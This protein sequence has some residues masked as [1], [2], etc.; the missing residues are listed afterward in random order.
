VIRQLRVVMSGF[1][2]RCFVFYSFVPDLNIH[3]GSRRWL[4]RSSGRRQPSSSSGQ[5]LLLFP[6]AQ[7]SR[8]S[9]A[10]WGETPVRN[11]TRPLGIGGVGFGVMLRFVTPHQAKNQ[12][13]RALLRTQAL[14]PFSFVDDVCDREREPVITA[15]PSGADQ[16]I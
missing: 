13:L 1:Y 3:T 15:T 9:A 10:S 8:R 11:P 6:V 4:P 7:P 5:R 16:N 12:F 2:W 14:M